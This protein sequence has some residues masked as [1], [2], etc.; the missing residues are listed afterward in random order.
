MGTVADFP[1]APSGWARCLRGG[2]DL[3]GSASLGSASRRAYFRLA[4]G[5]ITQDP[6]IHVAFSVSFRLDHGENRNPRSVRGI[7]CRGGSA[8]KREFLAQPYQLSGDD[9]QRSPTPAVFCLDRAADECSLLARGHVLVLLRADCCCGRSWETA[10]LRR[11]GTSQRDELVRRPLG[12][13]TDE[14]AR[15]G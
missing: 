2:H 1:V 5:D 9:H 14:H 8:E 7:F 3:G 10:W 15:L 11:R 13:R 6:C 12:R 4:A